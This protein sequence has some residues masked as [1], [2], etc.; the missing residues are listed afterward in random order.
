MIQGKTAFWS[1]L[2]LATAF[3]ASAAA[4]TGTVKADR[5]NVRGAAG[6]NGEVITQLAKGE[7]VTI[8]EP[9]TIKAGKGEPANWLKI[10]LPANTP[11]WVNAAFVGTNDLVTARKLNVRGG[12]GENFSVLARLEKGAALKVLRKEHEWLEIQAPDGA[13]AFVV[14]S[15]IEITG[16]SSEASAKKDA[17]KPVAA[18]KPEPTPVVPPKPVAPPTEVKTEPAPVV[19]HDKPPEPEA[20][21]PVVVP[22]PVPVPVVTPAAVTTVTADTVPPVGRKV[23]R[24][25]IVRRDLHINTP[26]YFSL[27][28]RETGN[29]IA[30]LVA[31]AQKFDLSRHIGMRVVISGEEFLD[32][33]WKR[34]PILKVET[35]DLP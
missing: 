6:L 27:E 26:S 15:F 9:V 35:L 11:L 29:K 14:A 13:A 12:P 17:A 28:D 19:A 33:R 18:A 2:F 5:V 24:E 22:P 31:N 34:T 10:A 20:P 21:K 7:S 25:G 3:V 16:T 30:F 8:L 4:T 1:A 23:F 32:E